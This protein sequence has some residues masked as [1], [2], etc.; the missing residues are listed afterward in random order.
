MKVLH[1]SSALSWRGG[2]QQVAYLLGEL[3]QLGIQQGVL[4]AK[5][6]AMA[7]F[8]KEHNFHFKTYKPQYNIVQTFLKQI[9]KI[10]LQDSSKK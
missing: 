10:L 8:C 9:N 5:G 6:S 7:D 4:C 2:E 1:F 3:K